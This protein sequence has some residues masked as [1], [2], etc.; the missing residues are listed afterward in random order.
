MDKRLLKGL[1]VVGLEIDRGW[2]E[3]KYSPPSFLAR[4]ECIDPARP[5]QLDPQHALLFCY[6]S[7]LKAFENYI[8]D[9]TGRCVVLI[10]PDNGNTERYCDPQ[11]FHL[12]GRHPWKVH[13]VIKNSF[14][15]AIVFYVRDDTQKTE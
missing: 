13:A 9:F 2:W 4:V 6:F 7:N 1:P 15:D 3:S 10:G 14:T 8:N 12:E 11:P 5:I